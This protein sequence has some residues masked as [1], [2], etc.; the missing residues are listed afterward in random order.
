MPFYWPLATL[1][2]LRALFE[3][4]VRPHHWAK[5]AHGVSPRTRMIAPAAAPPADAQRLAS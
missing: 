1:A 3:L 2:A 5:T 4:A